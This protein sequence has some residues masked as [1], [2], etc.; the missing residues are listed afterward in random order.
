MKANSV[1]IPAK[2]FM[3][4]FIF[5]TSKPVAKNLENI[6]PEAEKGIK[7]RQIKQKYYEILI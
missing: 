6:N 4:V 1:E 7:S 2:L 5:V 3:H